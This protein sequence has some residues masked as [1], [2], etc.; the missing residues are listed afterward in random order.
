VRITELDEDGVAFRKSVEQMASARIDPVISRTP[1]APLSKEIM[2]QLIRTVAGTG[3]FGTRISEADGGSGL[4]KVLAGVFLEHIPTFL[5]VSCVSQ[6]A[7]TYRLYLSA[8]PEVREAYLPQ[9][10]AGE[11]LAGTSVSEAEVGSDSSHPRVRFVRKGTEFQVVGSKLWTTNGSIADLLIVV[12]REEETGTVQRLLVDTRQTEV[13]AHE[14]PMTGLRRGHLCEV[15]IRGR[16]PA[17]NLLDQ[18]EVRSGQALAR[19]WTMNRISMA[20]LALSI[21]RR[22]V[23]YAISYARTREQFGRKIGAFQLVQGLIADSA[24]TVEAGRLLCYRALSALDDHV[25]STLLSSMAKLFGTETA[26]QAVIKAQQVAGSFGV[27][28]ESPFDEWYRDV[29]MFTFPDGTSQIQ[30]LI[31][32]RELL[33]LSAFQ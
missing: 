1:Q 10:I 9:L 31:I 19:S 24:T 33:G 6:E 18:S 32:G 2:A 3:Y 8:T 15:E 5:G 14:I 20:L 4:P 7:T 12:G 26:V 23:D 27:S 21:A 25:E 16:V 13:A 29:R 28:G 11:L 17:A 22:A 30:Q